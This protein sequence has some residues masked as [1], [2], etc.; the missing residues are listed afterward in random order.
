[1][2]MMNTI[3]T[4]VFAGAKASHVVRH[5]APYLLAMLLSLGMLACAGGGAA[6]AKT[7]KSHVVDLTGF[8]PV[9]RIELPTL[10]EPA[11]PAMAAPARFF[12]INKV[13]AKLDG[14]APGETR[15]AARTDG[16]TL[17]DAQASAPRPQSSEP[18]GLFT[19]Q[20]PE[21]LLWQKWRGVSAD[22]AEDLDAMARCRA[23]SDAC[24]PAATRFI[25]VIDAARK[26]DGRARLDAVDHAV[27]DAVRYMTDMQQHG[28]PDLWSSP[29]STFATLRGDCEDYAIAKYV[30]LREAGVAAGDLRIVLAH[31]NALGED[32][33]VLAARQDGHWF[34]LDNRRAEVLADGDVKH[35]APLFAVD[36]Q[37]V[38]LFAA[39]YV[40]RT[41]DRDEAVV[42]PAADGAGAASAWVATRPL[43]L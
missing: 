37:G 18:F 22:I 9:P 33:A 41:P 16:S 35:L 21:G 20:A 7:R 19:F 10:H 23:S 36:A 31:D 28:V 39:P 8:G 14:L 17:S 3:S 6:S 11:R 42:A 24:S 1:M 5:A 26:Y 4:Q 38:K 29:L 12:T 43:F 32:H 15:F 13:L 30:A 25:A 27:N 40:E 2:R 34:I